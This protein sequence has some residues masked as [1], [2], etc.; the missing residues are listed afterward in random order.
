MKLRGKNFQPWANFEID[1]DGL[2]VLVGPSNKGKSSLFRALRGVVRNDL[3]AEFVRD[4]QEEP[5]EVELE[6]DGLTIKATRPKKGAGSTKYEVGTKKYSS[7]GGKIPDEVEKLKFNTVKIDDDTVIDP[8]FAE[9]NKAQFLIDP[10]RWKPGQLNAI[11]GAFSSTEKLDSGKKEANLRVTQRKSEANTLA[12]EIREAEER[13]GELLDLSGQASIVAD[14]VRI[15]EEGI[16]TDEILVAQIEKALTHR[17]R[18]EPLEEILESLTIP[19]LAETGTLLQLASNLSEAANALALSRFLQRLATNL[20]TVAAAWSDIFSIYKQLKG[21]SEL[22]ELKD[23][24]GSSPEGYIKWFTEIINQIEDDLSQAKT[25]NDRI[26][27]L[28]VAAVTKDTLQGVRSR[29]TEQNT[30]LES[31]E[32]ELESVRQ[33]SAKKATEGICPKC[34]KPLE[35]VCQ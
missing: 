4:N 9:Q 8:I 17:S 11:L 5:L 35:H 2:T 19:D 25:L 32:T 33:E 12:S 1:I 14:A 29:L 24:Q 10:D 23:R 28:T 16:R 22:I 30:L 13:C 15:L 18:L 20:D 21:L 3:P 31:A 7:L 34:G 6:V 27:Y 26:S